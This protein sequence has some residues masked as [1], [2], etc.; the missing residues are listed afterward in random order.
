MLRSAIDRAAEHFASVCGSQPSRRELRDRADDLVLELLQALRVASLAEIADAVAVLTRRQKARSV[1][2]DADKRLHART[3]KS[4]SKRV[5]AEPRA[6]TP[7][8]AATTPARTPF[9]ITMPS[10]LLAPAGPSSEPGATAARAEAQAAQ[11]PAPR[12]ER[13]GKPAKPDGSAPEQAPDSSRSPRVALREGEELVRSGG[14]GAI[15][16]RTRTA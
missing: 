4:R 10:E 2:A 15:I 1:A 8:R 6:F 11:A 9:D 12:P 3:G 16:R 5:A 13:P 14:S 7:T